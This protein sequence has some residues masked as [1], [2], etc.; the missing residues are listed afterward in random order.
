V[1][2]ENLTALDQIDFSEP[3]ITVFPL[4]LTGA[5]GAPTRAVAMDVRT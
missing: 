5:D 2:V 3:L 1:V 4:R